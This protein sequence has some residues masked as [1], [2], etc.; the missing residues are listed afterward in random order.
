M[1]GYAR[2]E[3]AA[4]ADA[5]IEAGPHAPTLCGGWTAAD[6]AAHLVIRESRPDAAVGIV[7][8]PAAR[9]TARV[10]TALRDRTPYPRVVDR[11]R[12]GPPPWSPFR[13]GSLDEAA[14]T[15]EFFVHHED[16]R[17][18][19]EGWEPRRLDEEFSEVLWSRL[20]RS[21]RLMFR[22]S[23]VGVTLVCT[24]AGGGPLRTVLAKAATPQMV[25]VT[26]EAQELLLFAF[27]R[28]DAAR[29]ESAGDESAVARLRGA[30]LG[31]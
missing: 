14:N 27:G 19:A 12:A 22:A 26:G 28:K 10:Q 21:A 3:R 25:T 2:T 4:L 23:P 7:A 20:R 5:L 15:V 11:L 13:V 18:A 17:R 24:A 1:G 8:R 6:L 16:L 9:W 29:V 31:M 30:K